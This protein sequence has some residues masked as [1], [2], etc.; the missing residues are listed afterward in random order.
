MGLVGV[1]FHPIRRSPKRDVVLNEN[2]VV[3][4]RQAR[5]LQQVAIASETRPAKNDIVTLPFARR[6]AGIDQRRILAINRCRLTVGVSQ[7]LIRI[8][9]LHFVAAHQKDTA[10]AAI[11]PLLLFGRRRGPFDMQLHIAPRGLGLNITA[12][13]HRH[14]IAVFNLPFRRLAFGIA[15]VR[16]IFAVEQNHSVRGRRRGQGVFSRRN[17]R[18]MRPIHIMNFPLRLR[19]KIAAHT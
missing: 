9:H 15:P 1:I 8:E 16:Q 5:R 2:T 10:V 6:Q 3:H 18:R 13:L 4:N 17:H 14:H 11:L 7:A 12:A 19:A